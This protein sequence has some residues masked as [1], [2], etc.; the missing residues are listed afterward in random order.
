V[1]R[2]VT[3]IPELRPGLEWGYG[4]VVTVPDSPLVLTSLTVEADGLGLLRGEETRFFVR[5]RD[6]D[7]DANADDLNGDGIPEL[8]PQFF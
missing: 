5:L 8:F 3:A 6:E 4:A 2:Y 1:P 7:G